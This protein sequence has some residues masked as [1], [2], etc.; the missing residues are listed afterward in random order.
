VKS[1]YKKKLLVIGLVLSFA[2]VS[3]G[4]SWIGKKAVEET[5]GVSVDKDNESVKVKTKEGEAEIQAGENKLPD[6]FPEDFPIYEDAKISG[7]SKISTDQGTS[8][9]VQ[10]ET[11]DSM[12]AVADYYKSALPDSGYKVQATAETPDSVMYSLEKGGMVQ[13]TVVDGKTTVQITLVE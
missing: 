6:G 7:S 4:C 13:V 1:R 12:S 9:T 3:S 10:L 2:I 5:T 11:N 8:Y